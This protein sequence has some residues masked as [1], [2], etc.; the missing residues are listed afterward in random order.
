MHPAVAQQIHDFKNELDQG[1]TDIAHR[2]VCLWPDD[3][4]NPANGFYDR[5]S[6]N[7]SR[8]KIQ[9]YNAAIHRVLTSRLGLVSKLRRVIRTD[10][11]RHDPTL[12]GHGRIAMHHYSQ[13]LLDNFLTAKPNPAWVG[14]CECSSSIVPLPPFIGYPC[15]EHGKK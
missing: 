6:D 8:F 15:H 7:W 14:E 13:A 9:E 3:P 11:K 1:P 4:V 10:L 5:P 12:P 2:L